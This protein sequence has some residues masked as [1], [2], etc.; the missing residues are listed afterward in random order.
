MQCWRLMTP[1]A[2][3]FIISNAGTFASWLQ[4]A[5]RPAKAKV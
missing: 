2:Q 5:R 1:G 3:P 4:A